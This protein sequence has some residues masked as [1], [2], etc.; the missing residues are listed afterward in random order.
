MQRDQCQRAHPA[1]CGAV[2][3]RASHL[4]PCARRAR[5]KPPCGRVRAASVLKFA[6]APSCC[7]TLR[8]PSRAH[9]SVSWQ[10]SGGTLHFRPC[11]LRSCAVARA[12]VLQGGRMGLFIGSKVACV[13][14]PLMPPCWRVRLRSGCANPSEACVSPQTIFFY[15][16]A[17]SLFSCS[18]Q[19]TAPVREVGRRVLLGC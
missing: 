12:C 16:M 14:M 10:K 19:H 3:A 13:C 6:G 15:S 4:V 1:L 2:F 8:I 18:T 7:T 17:R 5:R 9:N 11:H